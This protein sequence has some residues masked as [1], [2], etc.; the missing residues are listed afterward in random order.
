MRRHVQCEA[1]RP[2]SMKNEEQRRTEEE[3]GVVVPFPARKASV[4]V[5]AFSNLSS[6]R[7]PVEG[8]DKYEKRANDEDDYPHRMKM[9]A[10]AVVFLAALIGGG[11]WIVDVMAQQRKNQ[12][13][14][15]SGR[16]N[17]API[18]ASS[19]GR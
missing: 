8:V 11:I 14:A 4:Q 16:R 7:S 9:N 3:S 10:L 15:L 17:C 18:S 19:T 12:D 13:C 1:E 2:L 6:E 5:H